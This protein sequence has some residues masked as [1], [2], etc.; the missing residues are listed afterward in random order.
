MT[1]GAISASSTGSTVPAAVIVSTI[2]AGSG[3]ASATSLG[4]SRRS[5]QSSS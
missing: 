2:A 4:G 5:C 1:W 3:L